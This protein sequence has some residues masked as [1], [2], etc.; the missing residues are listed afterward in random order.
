VQRNPGE[1]SKFD[2]RFV[3]NWTAAL[4]AIHGIIVLVLIGIAVGYPAASQWISQAIEAEYIIEPPASAPT[5]V[6]QP[7][8]EI[9]TA[10]QLEASVQR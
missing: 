9:R 1:L 8:E 6:A 4:L 2:Q 7:R 5:Q 3:A 10:G